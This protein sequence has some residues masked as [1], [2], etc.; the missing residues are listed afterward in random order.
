MTDFRLLDQ[1]FAGICW[2]KFNQ[3]FLLLKEVKSMRIVVVKTKTGV[4]CLP[5]TKNLQ[6]YEKQYDIIAVINKL[7]NPYYVTKIKNYFKGER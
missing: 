3:L 7:H 2:R 4:S 6:W 1:V 5:L